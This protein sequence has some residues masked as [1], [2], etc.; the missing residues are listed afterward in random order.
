MSKRETFDTFNYVKKTFNWSKTK[1]YYGY[2]KHDALNSPLLKFASLG[3]RFLRLAITQVVMRSPV[4]IRPLLMVPEGLNPKGIGLFAHA[5]CDLKVFL[6]KHPDF[7]TNHMAEYCVSETDSLLSWLDIHASPWTSPHRS[8]DI[9]PLKGKGW[10]YHYPWQD[11]GFFQPAHFP[12]RV[13]T[14]WIGFAYIRAYEMTGDPKYLQT[15]DDIG[16]FLLNNPNKIVDEPEQLCLSYVPLA[17]VTWAVMD[18]SA[19]AAAMCMRLMHH[20][21]ESKPDRSE[22]YRKGAH[23]LMAF[24]VDKQEEYGGWF[25]TWPSKDSHIKHDNYHTGIILDCLADYMS[26]SKDFEYLEVYRKGLDYYREN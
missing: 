2:S 20:L 3:N 12:N 24:V 11:V 6:D 13:V 23:R 4:N 21:K 8:H 17:T 22:L 26:Y 7:D 1:K 15:A 10:G 14:S 9:D 5:Y 18:V 19:L 25:Y 16:I